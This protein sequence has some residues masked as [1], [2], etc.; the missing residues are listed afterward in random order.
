MPRFASPL[1]ELVYPPGLHEMPISPFNSRLRD[2][3]AGECQRLV[4]A[5]GPG[6]GLVEK[7]RKRLIGAMDGGET[8]IETMAKQLAMSP[9]SL[10][11]RLADE[12]ARYNDLL[13]EIRAEFAKRYLARGTIS[14]SEVAYLV[15]G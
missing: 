2:Y 15:A 13:A 4:S 14:A 9:R 8:S 3:F 6:T 11:R 1:N 10:Q 5:L 7:V 12:G